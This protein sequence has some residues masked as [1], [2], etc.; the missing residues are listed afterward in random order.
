MI[1]DLFE[2]LDL[3]FKVDDLAIS[4]LKEIDKDPYSMEVKKTFHE[5]INLIKDKSG[6][7]FEINCLGNLGVALRSIINNG[8]LSEKNDQIFVI[9]NSYY[10]LT[11]HIN[12]PFMFEHPKLYINRALLIYENLDIFKMKYERLD[13]ILR[14][15]EKEHV[16]LSIAYNELIKCL[17]FSDYVEISANSIKEQILSNF[18]GILKIEKKVMNKILNLYFLDFELKIK[19]TLQI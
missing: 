13:K 9:I 6:I 8:L 10:C 5:I 16:L 17:D 14:V 12:D 15:Y 7:V 2:Y 3:E 4:Y 11:K 19:N 1:D 18:G